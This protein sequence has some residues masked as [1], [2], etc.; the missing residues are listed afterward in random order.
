MLPAIILV[1]NLLWV[2]IIP[3][4]REERRNPRC[5]T[6]MHVVFKLKETTSAQDPV[7]PRPQCILLRPPELSHGEVYYSTMPECCRINMR[8][9]QVSLFMYCK[10]QFKPEWSLTVHLQHVLLCINLCCVKAD[11]LN[12]SQMQN[13]RSITKPSAFWQ[14]CASQCMIVHCSVGR[15]D[16]KSMASGTMAHIWWWCPK[17]TRFW[18]RVFI[19]SV[20]PYRLESCQNHGDC[21]LLKNLIRSFLNIPN[22]WFHIWSWPLG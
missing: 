13:N 9:C 11:H 18:I 16:S 8:K 6:S 12:G 21:S 5:R 22:A 20:I 15:C 1:L 10:G 19:L 17:M 2:P 7:R 3:Q 4:W 14:S